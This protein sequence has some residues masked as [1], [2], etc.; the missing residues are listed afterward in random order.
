MLESRNMK[1]IISGSHH[2]LDYQVT[3]QAIDISGWADEITEVVSGGAT[4]PDSHA[5]AWAR[6][7]DVPVRNFASQWSEHGLAAQQV[8]IEQMASYADALILVWDGQ[9]RGATQMRQLAEQ[10]GLKIYEYVVPVRQS[11]DK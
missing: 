2:I 7:H 1:T 4:G 3:L 8:R 11:T 6:L 5:V 10:R 9:S